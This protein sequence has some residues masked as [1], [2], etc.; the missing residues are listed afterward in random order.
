MVQKKKEK[1]ST[2]FV[3]NLQYILDLFKFVSLSIYNVK[4]HKYLLLFS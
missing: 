1:V 3:K 2:F 4:Q